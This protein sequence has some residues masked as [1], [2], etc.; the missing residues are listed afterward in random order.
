[1]TEAQYKSA[2]A[3]VGKW[4]FLQAYEL[5]KNW[6][7]ENKPGLVRR[8]FNLG[9]DRDEAWSQARVNGILRIIDGEMDRRALEEIRDSTYVNNQHPEAHDMAEALIQRYF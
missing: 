5:V 3:T 1:M 8:V 9:Q 6:N 7:G 4:A 2:I